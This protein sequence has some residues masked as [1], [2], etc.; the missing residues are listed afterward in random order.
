[1]RF[2]DDTQDLLGKI[3]LGISMQIC[4]S[5]H[6]RKAKF[7]PKD[8]DWQ[9]SWRARGAAAVLDINPSGWRI[10][11]DYRL[12]LPAL[13]QERLARGL[14][15]DHTAAPEAIDP[16]YKG[17]VKRPVKKPISIDHKRYDELIGR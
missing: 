15:R 11:L 6:S 5:F 13:C 4:E 10:E 16:K 17:L 7:A 12:P 8:F 2:I 3:V 9:G 1:M 14:R